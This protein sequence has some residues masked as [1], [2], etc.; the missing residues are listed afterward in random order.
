MDPQRAGEGAGEGAG[1]QAEV[2]LV[3]VSRI[4]LPALLWN[5]RRS[6]ALAHLLTTLGPAPPLWPSGHLRELLR[7]HLPD[8]LKQNSTA[9]SLAQEAW[10]TSH[11]LLGEPPPPACLRPPSAEV[12]G[13]PC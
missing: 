8:L 3:S 9:I 12:G 4:P 7:C 5:I 1:V 6:H 2:V 11:R 10:G 13:Q